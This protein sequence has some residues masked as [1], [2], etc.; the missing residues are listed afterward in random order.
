MAVAMIYPDS[1]QGKKDTSAKNAEVGSRYIRMARSVLKHTP[2][3]AR[4]VLDNSAVQLSAGFA[5]HSRHLSIGGN[6]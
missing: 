6:Q 4:N 1:H 3:A 2:D 5:Y